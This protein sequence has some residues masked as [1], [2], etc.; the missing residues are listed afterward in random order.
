MDC[1]LY[2]RT[3]K[4]QNPH[5]Q[6]SAFSTSTHKGDVFD[7]TVCISNLGLHFSH[8]RPGQFFTIFILN[9]RIH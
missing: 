8:M 2:M 1:I 6:I 7:L 5:I 9:I 3:W 4:A